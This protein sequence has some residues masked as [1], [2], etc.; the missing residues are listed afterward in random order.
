MKCSFLR[1][2][3]SGA[4]AAALFPA[5]ALSQ[6]AWTPGAEVLGQPII[7]TTNS[8]T[9][10]V[11]LYAGG[12]LRILTPG[13]NPVAGT[14]TAANGQL[15]LAVGGAQECIPYSSPFQPGQPVRVTSSCNAAETWLAEMTN[16]LRTTKE[17]PE[18]G[19]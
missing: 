8:V 4:A 19:R 16:P 15:C 3:A 10:T 13:G 7:V 14:W 1:Q 18:R 17:A 2:A 9:N 6:G 11:Y 5:S 12:Q